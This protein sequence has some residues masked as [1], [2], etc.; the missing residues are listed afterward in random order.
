MKWLP[1]LLC[2]HSRIHLARAHK[3]VCKDDHH[4]VAWIDVHDC[5][6]FF[7]CSDCK[8]V[9]KPGKAVCP[10]DLYPVKDTL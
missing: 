3:D 9:L 5:Y 10:S 7:V 6:N 2:Q 4:K 8:T 1:A